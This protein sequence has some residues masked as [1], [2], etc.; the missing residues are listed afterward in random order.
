MPVFPNYAAVLWLSILT[1]FPTSSY[2]I[3]RLVKE[4]AA[5]VSISTVAGGV[6]NGIRD[7]DL[8]DTTRGLYAD[9]YEIYTETL[10]G[11]GIREG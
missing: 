9:L 4:M 1:R 11:E 8:A 3:D 6:Y 2:Y 5:L 10:H 7:A